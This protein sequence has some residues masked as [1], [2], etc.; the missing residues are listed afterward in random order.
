MCFGFCT[1][2][3]SFTATYS[4]YVPQ[5]NSDISPYTS[6][7]VLKSE[8]SCPTDTTT[9]ANSIPGIGFLGLDSPNISLYNLGLPLIKLQSKSLMAAA[10]TFTSTSFD[11]G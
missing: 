7:P 11:L 2:A 9:P 4:A 5:P 10:F 1:T 8:T 6:S 3:F